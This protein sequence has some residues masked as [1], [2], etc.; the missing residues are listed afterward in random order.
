[1]GQTEVLEFLAKNKGKWL[2]GRKISKGINQQVQ[3]TLQNLAKLRTTTFITW[4]TVKKQVLEYR[5]K[6]REDEDEEY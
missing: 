2:T 4:K 3:T 6:H 5:Y 1:M